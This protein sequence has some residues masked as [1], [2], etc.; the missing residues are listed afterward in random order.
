MPNASSGIKPV[1]P[2]SG[3]DFARTILNHPGDKSVEILLAAA[4]GGETDW[5]EKKAAVYPSRDK[6]PNFLAKLEKC[7]P[8]KIAEET[9]FYET[10]LLRT[11]AC[12]LVAL[13]NS[14]GGILLIGIDDANNPVPFETCDCDGILAPKGLES[15]VR[16][17]ILGRLL[18]KDGLFPCKKAVWAVPAASLGIES[19]VCSYQGTSVLALLVPPL[20]PAEPPVLVTRTENNRPRKLLL[21]REPGDV[22]ENRSI[23]LE[24]MWR[25][26][27]AALADFHVARERTFLSNTDLFGKLRE[28][29]IEPPSERF[30]SV[31]QSNHRKI[32]ILIVILLLLLLMSFS[33]LVVRRIT[34]P[35]EPDPL[36]AIREGIRTGRIHVLT[37]EEAQRQVN[38][39][40][41]DLRHSLDDITNSLPRN[42]ENSVSTNAPSPPKRITRRATPEEQAAFDAEIEARR[43]ELVKR[44]EEFWKRISDEETQMS[45]SVDAMMKAEQDR[46]ARDLAGPPH[47]IP[48]RS[49]EEMNAEV[50]RRRRERCGLIHPDLYGKISVDEEKDIQARA[51]RIARLSSK[52][53]SLRDAASEASMKAGDLLISYDS[54][55]DSAKTLKLIREKMRALDFSLSFVATNWNER[56]KAIEMDDKYEGEYETL[57]NEIDEQKTMLLQLLESVPEDVSNDISFGAGAKNQAERSRAA[58]VTIRDSLKQE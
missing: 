10:E 55:S 37:P 26:T 16:E 53:K 41:A 47:R 3:Y 5:L 20:E 40:L 1:Y 31:Q 19:K 18:P 34:S 7:P 25:D 44:Q 27:A 35:P 32:W 49:A 48:K 39:A 29:G 51:Q 17:S 56:I 54:H 43:T 13:H 14:R 46:R 15:Y 33:I 42:E 50:I 38:S 12:A 6:D 30:R 2:V 4:H 28:L 9:K 36:D 57:L 23:E 58:L 45:P 52:V 21:Q 8:E 22:G 24:S 11:I